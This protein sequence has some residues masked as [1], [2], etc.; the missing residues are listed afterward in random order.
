MEEEEGGE[1]PFFHYYGMLVHQQNMLQDYV[2]TG[3]YHTAVMHNA[4]DFLGAT[5]LDVGTGTGI[6]AMFAAQ[7]GARKVYAVE[8]SEMAKI[9]EKLV[10]ANM[11]DSTV[12]VIQA[13]VEEVSLP[14]QVDVV[15]S[16]PMGFLL[17]HE[18]MLE[19]FVVARN[20]F[21]KP[22]GK[23]FPSRGR[24]Y[25]A[26]FTDPILF[27]E[28]EAKVAFWSSTDFYG[29]NL[30][31]LQADAREQH[32]G[33][34]VI[35][36]IDPTSLLTCHG[37][38]DAATHDVDFATC[39]VEDLQRIEIPFEFVVARTALLHGLAC[40]FDV[41]FDGS[42][43]TTCLSTGPSDPATHWYQCRLLVQEPLAVNAG[44][45]IG[46]KLCMS[47]NEK[48]SYDL[49]LTVSILGTAEPAVTR[50]SRINLQDQMYAYI[51]GNN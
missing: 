30:S 19:S 16:E 7:A 13:K 37:V 38:A 9:A 21:L 39:S 10:L 14:E 43:N 35:G 20:R 49:I 29:V 24:I 25:I 48:Y 27:A 18:R 23:M 3:A 5:V 36:S 34:P 6:L 2:R 42:G 22:G 46:G 32:F 11:L 4:S 17:V 50:T 12:Q 28:Q 45:R 47:A 15:V 41:M 44:Q 33:Q 40:W 1:H 51:A 26:P 8:A 31:V